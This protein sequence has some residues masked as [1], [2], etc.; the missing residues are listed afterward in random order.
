[1]GAN[2]PLCPLIFSRSRL[3][4]NIDFYCLKSTSI[5]TLF[6]TLFTGNFLA[7]TIVLKHIHK[8]LSTK[9]RTNFINF[10]V[11]CFIL[12]EVLVNRNFAKV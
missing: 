7:L 3:N 8:H 1:M 10:F 6:S 4:F 9:H 11:F 12:Q 5:L 2:Q